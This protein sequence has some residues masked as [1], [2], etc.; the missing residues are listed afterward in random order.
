MMNK[1]IKQQFSIS[2]SVYQPCLSGGATRFDACNQKKRDLLWRKT[3]RIS[4]T[5]MTMLPH[6]DQP[7]TVFARLPEAA[8]LALF[9]RLGTA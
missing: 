9:A 5:N 2:E 1:N 6:S 7:C 8:S 4:F 3:L